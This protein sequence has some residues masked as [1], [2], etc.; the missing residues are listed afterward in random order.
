MAKVHYDDDETLRAARLRYWR[1][2]G[3]G[4]D[5]G[6]NKKWDVVKIGPVPMPIRNIS[7]RRDAIRYHDLHHVVTGYDTDLAGEA[8]ISAW[9]VATGCSTKWVAW[10]LDL[11]ALL[12]M[13][14]WPGRLLRAMARGRASRSLYSREFDEAMLD[15]TV[16]QLRTELTLFEPTGDPGIADV[17]VLCFWFGL[18][19]VVHLGALA[20]LCW[21]GYWGLSQMGLL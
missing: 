14:L 2:N 7:A 1:A 21:G 19:L 16:G 8:E 20:V 12:L 17:V 18:S 9:E 3:F 11:Q 15:M 5:G 13:P 10:V 4:D 6:Y